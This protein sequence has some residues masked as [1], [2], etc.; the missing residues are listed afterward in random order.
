MVTVEK[1]EIEKKAAPLLSEDQ[2]MEYLAQI[3]VGAYF[4]QRKHAKT[5]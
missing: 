5:N 3:L 2:A 4:E 1:R